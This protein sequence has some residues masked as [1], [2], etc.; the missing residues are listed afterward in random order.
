MGTTRFKEFCAYPHLSGRQT[1]LS[2]AI[3]IPFTFILIALLIF[4]SHIISPKLNLSKKVI[5]CA[6]SKVG[7][8][9]DEILNYK[10][11]AILTSICICFHIVFMF[12]KIPNFFHI[13][14]M[15]IAYSFIGFLI[16]CSL[17]SAISYT[18][19]IIDYAEKG[20]GVICPFMI[21]CNLTDY[22]KSINHHGRVIGD[23]YL[24]YSPTRPSLS[25]P[26]SKCLNIPNEIDLEKFCPTNIEGILN[27]AFYD[28]NSPLTK[29]LVIDNSLYSSLLNLCMDEQEH[30]Y[31]VKFGVFNVIILIFIYGLLH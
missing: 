7:T 30:F 27:S 13:I 3:L 18:F 12:F 17:S 10:A 31:M 8:Y 28:P 4:S 23:I 19:P 20:Y 2:I 25:I 1:F 29:C 16:S 5:P 14:F 26:P 24:I 15:L 6:P 9:G 11:V 21:P 22:F